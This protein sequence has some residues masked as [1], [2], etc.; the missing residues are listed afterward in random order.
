MLRFQLNFLALC[1]DS[2]LLLLV[3]N[4]IDFLLNCIIIKGGLT[5]GMTQLMLHVLVVHLQK[6]QHTFHA[7]ERLLF[8]NLFFIINHPKLILIAL[9][10]IQSVKLFIKRREDHFSLIK[11]KLR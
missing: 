9:K 1:L 5:P 3:A 4:L 6:L 11:A 8:T 10:F 7:S 2:Q